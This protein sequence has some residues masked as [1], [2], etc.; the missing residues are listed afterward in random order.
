MTPS[1]Q[2]PSSR[3]PASSPPPSSHPSDEAK[4]AAKPQPRA[5]EPKPPLPPPADPPV[6]TVADEQRKRS[7]E[8]EAEG[9]AKYMARI[10]E[11][12]ADLKPK[13]VEGVAP[14]SVAPAKE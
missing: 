12:P 7:A 14:R 2:P 1:S 9:M 8:I 4:T 6:E 5:D 10:D 3:S 11:R 13:A